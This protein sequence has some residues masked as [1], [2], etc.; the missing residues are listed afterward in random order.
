M[1][2]PDNPCF[3]T[4]WADRLGYLEC[5]RPKFWQCEFLV[6]DFHHSA[7][8]FYNNFAFQTSNSEFGKK[9][10]CVRGWC[11]HLLITQ[12]I[13]FRKTGIDKERQELNILKPI[14]QKLFGFELLSISRSLTQHMPMI[15]GDRTD[16]AP[17]TIPVPLRCNQ[18]H[19]WSWAETKTVF[20]RTSKKNKLNCS[21]KLHRLVISS[22][23]ISSPSSR[24]RVRCLTDLAAGV[25][26]DSHSIL[27]CRSCLF[28]QSYR[29]LFPDFSNTC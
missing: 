2:F 10:S 4:N 3:W 7:V 25:V 29:T 6:H 22:L 11:Y 17:K 13:H 12:I 5:F 28:N 23:S 9:P 24:M 26:P 27:I 18:E 14:W 19:R 15:V 20:H 16:S 1:T 8:F 21:L